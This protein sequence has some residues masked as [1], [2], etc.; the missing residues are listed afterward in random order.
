MTSHAKPQKGK[1]P[2]RP[3]RPEADKNGASGELP[4]SGE[5]YRT[6][7]ENT[8]T[9]IIIIEDDGLISLA[10]REF[11]KISGYSVG[12][13]AGLKKWM[14]FMA[15]EDL[16]FMVSQHR[17]RRVSP[18][19][20][21]RRYECRL[22]DRAGKVHDI[23]LTVDLVPGTKQSVASMMDITERRKAEEAVRRSEKEYG[24]LYGNMPDGFISIDLTGRIREVNLSFEAITGYSAEELRSMTYRDL[25][26]EKWLAMEKDIIDN[27]VLKRG[28]SDI[29]EKEYRRKDGSI[30][31]VELHTFVSRDKDGTLEKIWAIVRDISERKRAEKALQ[32]G[33]EEVRLIMASSLDAILQMDPSGKLYSANPAACEM[34]GRTEEELQSVGRSGFID[35]ADPRVAAALEERR[36]TGRFQGEVTFMRKDGS[37]FTGELSSVIYRDG[38]GR[39][40]TSMVVRDMTEREM[41]EKALRASEALF[42][43]IFNSSPL[44]I[45]ILRRSDG[46]FL[47][48]NESWEKV[49]GFSREETVGKGALSLIKYAGPAE[50]EKVAG[51]LGSAE[52]RYEIEISLLRKTG[53]RIEFLMTAVPIKAAGEDCLLTTGLEITERKRAEETRRL[54]EERFE[55]AFK[56]SPIGMAMT[57]IPE[58]KYVDVN[59][60]LLKATGYSREDLIGKVSTELGILDWAEREDLIYRVE[61]T[62]PVY[63]MEMHY[64][65]KTGQVRDCLMSMARVAVGT[66]YYYLSSTLDITERKRIETA[67]QESEEDLFEHDGVLGVTHIDGVL[68]TGRIDHHKA[69]GHEGDDSDP[70]RQI[71]IVAEKALDGFQSR[72]RSRGCHGRLFTHFLK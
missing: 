25:T 45:A 50:L 30:V 64:R 4:F 61:S 20:A 66:E 37:R 31:P 52:A 51:M 70:Q 58:G 15:P 53:E 44:G 24:D 59:E 49:M 43:G 22:I 19:S 17:L 32:A 38:E 28:Y 21:L 39:E 9:A 63:S 27:Q 26:P 2:G 13:I 47:N 33:R 55:I 60:A 41:A 3:E 11:E 12:E 56:G 72:T 16:D 48:V 8:G 42:S 6:I 34:F 46:S 54:S 57:S 7:F 5:M 29:F 1:G 36:R 69:K 62:G 14:D 67:A 18:D 35:V 68:P 23:S 71:E 65:R 40:R 10:N